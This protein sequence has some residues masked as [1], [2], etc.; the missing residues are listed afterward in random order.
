MRLHVVAETAAETAVGENAAGL[1]VFIWTDSSVDRKLFSAFLTAKAVA[2]EFVENPETFVDR[3][4]A[5]PKAL[6]LVRVNSEGSQIS[7]DIKAD[8]ECADRPLLVHSSQALKLGDW[9][10]GP[11]CSVFEVSPCSP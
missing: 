2:H 7:K 9:L 10:G 11:G 8:P 5:R 4:K 6:A 1:K 3:M